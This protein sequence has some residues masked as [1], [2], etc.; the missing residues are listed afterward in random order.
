[1]T[2]SSHAKHPQ[3]ILLDAAPSILAFH[4]RIRLLVPLRCDPFRWPPHLLDKCDLFCRQVD[5]D[6]CWD[7]AELRNRFL[8]VSS[9]T[10]TTG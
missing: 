8:L 3:D 1:M 9:K 5:V 7:M 2:E 10:E 4:V 6:G